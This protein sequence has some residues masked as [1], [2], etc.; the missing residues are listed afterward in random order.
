MLANNDDMALGAI[1]AWKESGGALYAC[2]SSG[3]RR[4]RSG[5]LDAMQ[6]G[7][8]AGTVVNY[9][10]AGKRMMELAYS[11]YFQTPADDIELEEDTYIRL[12]LRRL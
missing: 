8:L 1:D 12:P 2:R 5:A 11:L 10:R 7:T 3:G 6:E 4:H 9:G